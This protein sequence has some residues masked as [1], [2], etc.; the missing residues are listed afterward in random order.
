MGQHG[1]IIEFTDP[2]VPSSLNATL[3]ATFLPHVAS[4]EGWGHAETIAALIRKSGYSGQVT[5]AL[6]AGLKVT[7]Y[8]STA[9]TLTYAEYR[10]AKERTEDA[11]QGHLITVAA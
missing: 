5:S 9:Y 6:L 11:Q 1:L 10:Q 7:R 2:T 4:Q 3:T 8:Q